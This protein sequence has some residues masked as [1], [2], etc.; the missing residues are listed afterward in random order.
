MPE[1]SSFKKGLYVTPEM[2]EKQMAY[3]VKMNYKT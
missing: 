2:F 1:G 3:L